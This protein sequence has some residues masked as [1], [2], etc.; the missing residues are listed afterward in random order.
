[1]TTEEQM[2]EPDGYCIIHSRMTD[3]CYFGPFKTWSE[4][5]AWLNDHKDVRGIVIPLYLTVDWNR[6]G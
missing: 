3:A 2:P 6:R 4:V 5:K 1:M